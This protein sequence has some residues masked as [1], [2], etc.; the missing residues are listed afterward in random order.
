M[1]PDRRQSTPN[2]KSQSTDSAREPENPAKMLTPIELAAWLNVPLGWI[3]GRTRT[4]RIPFRRFGRHIRFIPA[5]ISKW[6]GAHAKSV[7]NP[8]AKWEP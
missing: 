1:K 3:Y 5:E 7:A 8:G 6:M 4:G 2:S